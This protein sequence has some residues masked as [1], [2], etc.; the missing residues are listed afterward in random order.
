[1]MIPLF[2]IKKIF[3]I[4]KNKRNLRALLGLGGNLLIFALG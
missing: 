1:M 2:V 4:P 3:D